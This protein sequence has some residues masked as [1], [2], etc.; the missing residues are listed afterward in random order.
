[1]PQS[2]V[3]LDIIRESAETCRD[4]AQHVMG[5]DLTY[6]E[7]SL[8]KVDALISQGWPVGQASPSSVQTWGCFVGECLCR[9]LGGQVGTNRSGVGCARRLDRR[10]SAREGG[11]ANAVRAVRV[12]YALLRSFQSPNRRL[13]LALQRTSARRLLL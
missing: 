1:M 6:D 9:L 5:A 7:Q 2:T 3:P 11:E 13:T 8:R 10:T 4:A 12:D